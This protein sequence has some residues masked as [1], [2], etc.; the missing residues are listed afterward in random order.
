MQEYMKKTLDYYENNAETYKQAWTDDFL[1]SYDFTV[2]NI[3]LEF[4]PSGASILD[5]GCGTGRDSLYFLN[6]GYN[7]TAVDG[8]KEFCEMSSKLL[9]INVRKLNFL[10]LDYNNE[11]DGVFACASL[12]HLD[13]KDLINVLKKIHTSL[14]NNGILYCSFK[15]GTVTRF[16]EKN[17]FYNDMTE[18]KFKNILSK[19]SVKYEILKIWEN[20]QYKSNT[21]FINFILRRIS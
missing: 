3:F 4:L 6:H 16:D 20:N 5:L 21:K 15:K 19:L 10:D 2:P 8:A 9:N 18:E 7:V 12:L 11:F 14:K 1:A 17:R 13:T